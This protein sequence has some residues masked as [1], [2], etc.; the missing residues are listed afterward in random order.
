MSRS[1]A[2]YLVLLAVAVVL[3]YWKTLL[4]NQFTVILGSEGVNLT[5]G[6]LHFWVHSIRQGHIP[7]W[8]PYAFAGR[9]FYGEVL[10][11]NFF[12]LQLFFALFP[13]TRDGL[14]SP[15]IYHVVLALT[16]LLCTYFMFALLR[17][18]RCSRFASFVGACAFSMGGLL[19][20]MMWPPYVESCI[21]LPAIFFFLL[22]ALRAS[23]KNRALIEAALG[24]LCLGMSI[25]IGGLQFCILQGIFVVTAVLFYGVCWPSVDANGIGS[26]AIPDR[27]SHWK[28]MGWIL[29]VFLI[30]S[31]A[32]GAVQLLPAAEYS[33]VTIRFIDGG[34]FPSSQ[35][36]PYHRMNP[37]M[38]PQSILTGLF[39]M[40]FGGNFG[41][42][43]TWPYYIGVLPFLLA[44]VAIWRRWRDLWVRYLAGLAVV[45]FAYSLGEFSAL[46]GVLYAVVPFLWVARS[47]SRI[48]YL[49]SFALA[50][51]AAFGLDTLL[52]RN[53]LESSW[54]PAKRIL[55]WVAVACAAALLIPGL[56]GQISINNWNAFSVLLILATCG[57]LVYLI[58]HPASAWARVILAFL[59]LFDLGSFNWLE[60]DKT[61][62]NRTNGELEQMVSL[63]APS[64]FIKAQPGL[65]RTRV[66]VSVE[67]N[68]GDIYSVQTVWGGGAT[69]LTELG[70]LSIREDLLNVRY[71]I[72]PASTPDPGAVYQDAK[73][74]IYLNPNAYPRAWIVHKT[75]LE[76]SQDAVFKH[77]DDAGVDLHETAILETPLAQSLDPSAAA[78]DSVQFR[79]Y[80]ADRMLIDSSSNSGGLL[81]LSEMFYPGWRAAVNGKPE[82]IIRVDGALRGILIPSGQSRIELRFVPLTVYW[83]GA[84]S[85][86]AFA[87]VLAAAFIAWRRGVA[88]HVTPLPKQLQSE[89]ELT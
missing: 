44:V 15:R 72:K 27:R 37:G 81:V 41:G 33:K 58:H 7:L 36:I 6:W 35:K 77:L 29:A 12:P 10:P 18:L 39:P 84:I 51:L 86:L 69:V 85:L 48:L 28:R 31:G 45:A 62:L 76:Q 83:G 64:N 8:D 63:R 55:K 26:H 73:W 66:R 20:R 46:N 87:G 49:V 59:V 47:P 24:G 22:R 71:L 57:L 53:I 34:P 74:K 2:K 50:V 23:S 1:T 43:E 3:F 40:A 88:A 17:E 21:W 65:Y 60:A 42:G 14:I 82:K 80:E 52:D 79:S 32:A 61:Q 56:F 67:P 16:H 54:A 30:V 78:G 25:L 68:I 9:P 75:I 4:T 70:Q 11:S 38:W 13:F 5:Y 19:A 89:L